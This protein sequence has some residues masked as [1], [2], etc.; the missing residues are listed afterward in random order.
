MRLLNVETEDF[1][2]FEENSA[3]RYAIL[4]HTW[5]DEEVT[6]QDM[7]AGLARGKNGYE[8]TRGCCHQA[9]RDRLRY[10]WIDT[11]C[12]DKR[13]SSE[14]S[15]AIN[16]MYRWYRQASCCHV[17][18]DDYPSAGTDPLDQG[19]IS[20]DHALAEQVSSSTATSC[21]DRFRHCRWFTRGWTLQ[22]LL[23][24]EFLK[25]YNKIWTCVGYIGAK[26]SHL[27]PND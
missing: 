27:L 6:F 16:S 17:F 25:F 12:I 15:E 20:C 3:P 2:D 24:P 14:L 19:S 18:L 4:S 26:T 22:E 10:A 9:E 23:A 8:K 21:R 11:C 5:R 13:S 1:H 7:S